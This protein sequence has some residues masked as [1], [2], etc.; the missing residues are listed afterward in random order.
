MFGEFGKYQVLP[1]DASVATRLA[2]PRPSAVAGRKVFT[3]SGE[4]VTGIP[5]SAAPSLLNT[6]YTITADIDVPADGADG[7]IVTHG[8]RFG[9][10]GLYLMKGKPVFT[11]NL[12]D[13]KRVKWRSDTALTPGKHTIVYDF[14]YDGLGFATIAFNSMSGIGHGGV[15]VLSVDGKEVARETME[16]TIPLVLPWDETLDIG[17]DTGTPVDD[18]DYQVPFAFTGK[19][20]K[21]TIALDPPRLTEDDIKKLVEA[22]RA[23]GDAN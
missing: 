17:A 18:Q 23:A 20:D 16:R 9:G 1:L 19:I 3:Y 15:G 11:W 4:P 8:G 14:K 13:L 7:M 22:Q 10:Y 21:L 2:Y 6:S 12:L 5:A